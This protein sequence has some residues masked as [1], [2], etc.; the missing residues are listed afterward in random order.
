MTRHRRNGHAC[1]ARCHAFVPAR[2]R[3]RM[4]CLYSIELNDATRRTRAGVGRARHAR[5]PLQSQTA[6]HTNCG[7]RKNEVARFITRA[8]DC[9]LNVVVFDVRPRRMAA[10]ALSFALD[11]RNESSGSETIVTVP[12]VCVAGANFIV[13]TISC[14]KN[15]R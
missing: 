15:T 3:A 12:V 2:R 9:S 5:S 14:Q 6:P 7:R 13:I 1:V 10:H 4:L 11:W 8:L